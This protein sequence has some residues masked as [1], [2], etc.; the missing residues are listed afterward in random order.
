MSHQLRKSPQQI[1]CL[2]KSAISEL[3][4]TTSYLQTY[5]AKYL[6]N[7]NTIRDAVHNNKE[8]LFRV[9]DPKTMAPLEVVY[10]P[11]IVYSKT[12]RCTLPSNTAVSD[13]LLFARLLAMLP[14]LFKKTDLLR[15]RGVRPTSGKCL[16]Q[17]KNTESA[18]DR[19]PTSV[20]LDVIV[21]AEQDL[22]RHVIL[23]EMKE[24]ETH[25]SVEFLSSLRTEAQ[26]NAEF[27]SL[28]K[29][30]LRTRKRQCSPAPLE[31]NPA[32]RT[33]RSSRRRTRVR[34]L[35]YTR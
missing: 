35:T 20:C 3:H 14:Q 26:N 32:K 7:R 23:N 34:R 30:T 31:V 13:Y 12:K 21:N 27:S 22:L 17:S 24:L 28:V 1:A 18:A 2:A 5:Q 15:Q 8:I 4:H 10:F 25:A 19:D 9:I 11:G 6:Q 33:R 16:L 29:Q